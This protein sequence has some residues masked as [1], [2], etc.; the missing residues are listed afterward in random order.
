M[1]ENISLQGGCRNLLLQEV[2]EVDSA[3]GPHVGL[4]KLEDGRF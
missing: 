3:G 4:G 1:K 2:A